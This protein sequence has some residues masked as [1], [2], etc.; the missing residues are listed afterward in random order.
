MKRIL[1][2]LFFISLI[3]SACRA[4]QS[5]AVVGTWKL[6]SY[7]SKN[8]PVAAV[9]DAAATL[10][11]DNRGSVTGNGGCNSLGGEYKVDGN[12]ITFDKIVST[13]MA[14]DSARMAQESA[15]TKVLSGTAEYEI[16]DNTLTLSNI[17]VVLVFSAVANQ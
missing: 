1:L 10:T 17:D 12:Q 8:Y 6:S 2:L 3:T 13:L 14:C 7:G 5:A 4:Q 9:A 15:V 11:F 16:K